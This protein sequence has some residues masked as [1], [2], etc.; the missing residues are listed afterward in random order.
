VW[1]AAVL[2][3]LLWQWKYNRLDGGTAVDGV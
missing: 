3:Q 2:L 1:S